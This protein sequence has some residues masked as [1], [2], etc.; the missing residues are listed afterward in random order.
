[1]NQQRPKKKPTLVLWDC[2]SMFDIEDEDIT[3]E[4]EIPKTNVTTGN[5]S[6]LKEYNMIF[7]KIK[8]LQENMIKMK[9]N[10]QKVN[11]PEFV[12]TS[13]NPKT[14]NIPVKSIENKVE[15]VKKNT[16]EHEMGYDIVEDI[17]KTKENISLFEMCNLPQQ[18]E[19]LLKALETP[20]KEP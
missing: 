7:P 15:N 14:V 17:K 11:I 20:M 2:V 12:I 8:K 18:K 9:N 16:N 3:E 6:S 19:K 1:M 13:Q 5:Q 4:E 10:F